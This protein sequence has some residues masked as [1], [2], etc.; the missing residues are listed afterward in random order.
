MASVDD[1][2]VSIKFDNDSFQRK[3]AET[4]S[5]LDKLK[6][7]MDFSGARRGLEEMGAAGKNFNLS[8]VTSAVEGVSAKFLAMS[9]VAITALVNITSQAIQAGA[10][11]ASAFTI[12]PVI[13]GF[14]EYETQLN[15]VQT[16]L[17]NTASKGTTLEEVNGALQR[18]NEYSDQTIYNFGEMARNIG[19]FTAAGVDLDTSVQSI[20]GIANLAAMSGSNS[21]QAAT[22]M[23]QLSQA[24]SAGSV[25]LMDWNSVV[26]AGM[27]GEAF[28]SALFETGKAMGSLTGVPVSQ[29]FTEWEDAGNSFRESLEKGWITADVLTTT[30]AGF[31]GDLTKEMLLQKGFTDQQADNILKTAAIAKA[32]ATEVKTFTQL[33]GTVKEAVGTGWADSFKIIVGNFEEAKGLWTMV[34]TTMGSIIKRSSDVRNMLLQAWK[35]EGGRGQLV[36]SLIAAFD[37]LRSIITPIKEAFRDIFPPVTV[38]TLLG[39]ST[40][41]LEFSKRIKI[42]GETADKLKSIFKGLFSIIEIGWNILKGLITVI[43]SFLSALSPA[44]SQLFT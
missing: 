27:G 2:V 1:R 14:H 44:G 19:T 8:G 26:N 32:A 10:R 29:S 37:G 18:L 15:S 16:I 25:K 34:N 31:T 22:A 43:K 9:T 5:S 17:A 33:V 4:I 11:I 13:E 21:E 36:E 40:A 28:K 30:L 35:N 6:S 24:I 7:S 41:V 3:I 39:M 12:K 23:Y 20:K 38:Q 42:G